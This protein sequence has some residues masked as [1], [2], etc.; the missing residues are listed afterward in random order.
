[1]HTCRKYC[2]RYWHSGRT[3]CIMVYHGTLPCVDI[4]LTRSASIDSQ[5]SLVPTISGSFL[6]SFI[7]WCLFSTSRDYFQREYLGSLGR[8]DWFRWA[9]KR[10]A[11]TWNAYL[12]KEIRFQISISGPSSFSGTYEDLP[13]ILPA[14]D[15][16]LPFFWAVWCNEVLR[17]HLRPGVGYSC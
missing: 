12:S 9:E 14:I 4:W 11:R 16:V 7:L 5:E 13:T 15:G 3:W 10:F 17:E 1:M 2:N 6:G 8:V